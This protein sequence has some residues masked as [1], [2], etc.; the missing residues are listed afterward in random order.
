MFRKWQVYMGANDYVDM[1][2]GI[3]SSML[4][5]LG[6]RRRRRFLTGFCLVL[7]LFIGAVWT[8]STPQAFQ[9]LSRVAPPVAR[10][11]RPDA[12]SQ[13][14]SGI[15]L[16]LA[17]TERVG[18]ALQLHLTMEDLE[19][20]RLD[21]SLYPQWWEYRQS[22]VASGSC[23]RAYDAETGLLHLYLT[24]KP[25]ED[26]QDFDW[27]Q[28][29]TVTIHD[30]VGTHQQT[31]IPLPLRLGD[32]LDLAITDGLTVAHTRLNEGE[33]RVFVRG[34]GQYRLLLIGP[35]G[36]QL[37]PAEQLGRTD[38]TWWVYHLGSR[39]VEACSLAALVDTTERIEG[40]WTIQVSPITEE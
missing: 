25:E 28:W 39:N 4:A 6:Q 30:L 11:L 2:E 26:L 9:W 31:R 22:S 34:D 38:G 27:D 12:G 20:D 29:V 1:T 21:S 37:A 40:T 17:G 32:E 5:S 8:A 18:N 15:R 13:E 14:E 23:T 16:E 3:D 36:E 35:L 7:A 33:L 19:A 24:C 10:L